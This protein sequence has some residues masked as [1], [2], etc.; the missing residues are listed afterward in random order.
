MKYDGL[1]LCGCA[2]SHHA[3]AVGWSK[4]IISYAIYGR[5]PNL[6]V[7]QIK[8]TFDDAF[9]SWQRHIDREFKIAERNEIVDIAVTMGR[10][11]SG[12]GTLAWS[13]MPDGLDRPLEQRYDTVEAWT[14]EVPPPPTR[15]NLFY[16][17]EHEIGH[18]IGLHHMSSGNRMQA[19]YSGG[20]PELQPEE[21]AAAQE[22]YGARPVSPNPGPGGGDLVEVRI[23]RALWSLI[24]QIERAD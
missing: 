15:V 13:E 16:V 12:G 2:E 7:S 11:D 1:N 14:L 8:T 9:D 10:I 20:I 22:I 6:S 23:P 21:I 3:G 4:R 5:L 19:A 17:A 24:D 18:A